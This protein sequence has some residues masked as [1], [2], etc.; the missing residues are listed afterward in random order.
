M[1]KVNAEL[2]RSRK[3]YKKSLKARVPAPKR[4]PIFDGRANPFSG[5]FPSD[6]QP[7]VGLSPEDRSEISQERVVQRFRDTH[8]EIQT[9][10]TFGLDGT[11]KN[12]DEI[13][14]VFDHLGI[15]N[16]PTSESSS[17]T[18]NHQVV[19][20]KVMG[21]VVKEKNSSGS[22]RVKTGPFFALKTQV[23]DLID[24]SDDEPSNLRRQANTMD[25]FGDLR[26]FL[27]G[28]AKQE[29]II[30]ETPNPKISHQNL[31]ITKE[32]DNARQP[33]VT[34]IAPQEPRN[35]GGMAT[36]SSLDDIFQ[37][38]STLILPNHFSHSEKGLHESLTP[39]IDSI[40]FTNSGSDR[41][42]SI[43]IAHSRLA[44]KIQTRLHREER[45]R[46][47]LLKHRDPALYHQVKGLRNQHL[48]VNHDICAPS[49]AQLNDRRPSPMSISV[50]QWNFGKT[51]DAYGD[52]KT[53]VMTY[54]AQQE[55][56]K[57]EISRIRNRTASS[58]FE[59]HRHQAFKLRREMEEEMRS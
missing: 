7:L 28:K 52:T 40:K 23:D 55:R 17:R 49:S 3:A 6:N 53:R 42:N 38:L 2:E 20:P 56:E 32:V 44:E 41:T 19:V 30:S 50:K 10:D 27:R 47:E 29:K 48:S 39:S 24:F 16:P 15:F 12:V 8:N 4:V 36:R 25:P 11:D 46:L 54:V 9:S 58:I 14:E 13:I 51:W 57:E 35:N 1:L 18:T 34:K 45:D 37:D 33:D 22:L 31:E 21:K 43:G 26:S 5:N 59:A